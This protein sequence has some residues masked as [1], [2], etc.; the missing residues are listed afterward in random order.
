MSMTYNSRVSMIQDERP[1]LASTSNK[2]D[3]NPE[4]DPV[5]NLTFSIIMTFGNF[6][7]QTRTLRRGWC[8]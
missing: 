1:S 5:G 4:F 2:L 6:Q 8:A 7:E 3:E